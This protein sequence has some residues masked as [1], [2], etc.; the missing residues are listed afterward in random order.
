MHRLLD[1]HL[2]KQKLGFY[3]ESK[4]TECNAN[5]IM[6]RSRQNSVTR[7]K[8]GFSIKKL[9]IEGDTLDF[10][11]LDSVLDKLALTRPVGQHF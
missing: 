4:P 5:A 2:T 7:H 10:E 9:I 8:E 1:A 11:D 6:P 3:W